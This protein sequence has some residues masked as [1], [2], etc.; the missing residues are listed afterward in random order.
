MV[1]TYEIIGLVD[2]RKI[3]SVINDYVFPGLLLM[4]AG[5]IRYSM[6]GVPFTMQSFVI[7]L[8]ALLGDT[9]KFLFVLGG[10]CAFSV[11]TSPDILYT[12]GYLVGFIVATQFLSIV[13]VGALSALWGAVMLVVAQS[14][15][16]T[17][18]IVWL[19]QIIGIKQA[20]MLG[21]VPFILTDLC[22]LAV[23][24]AIML[25]RGRVR[26]VG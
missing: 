7:M 14:I 24:F 18:G 25:G 11:M 10:Y 12:G 3:A 9:R 23:I 1:K 22:K 17:C 19:C 16:W 20:V 21:L 13:K 8:V 26:M 2:D 6:G 5:S 15:V 4:V